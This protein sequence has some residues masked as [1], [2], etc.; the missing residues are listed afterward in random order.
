MTKLYID[1]E[2]R[3]AADIKAVG[4]HKYAADPTTEILCLGYAFDDHPVVV[5]PGGR[6]PQELA[7]HVAGGGVVVAHNIEFDALI[8]NRFF[9]LLPLKQQRCTLA[10]CRVSAIPASLDAAGKF[11]DLEHKKATTGKI[12]IGKLAKPVSTDPLVWYENA[13]ALQGLYDYCKQDVETCRALDK[14]LPDLSSAEQEVWCLDQEI[15][16]RGIKVDLELVE[17]AHAAATAAVSRL[18]DKMNE[19]T[20]GKVASHTKVKQLTEW[21]RAKGVPAESLGKADIEELLSSDLP[22][23]VRAALKIRQEAAKSSVAKYAKILSMMGE[24]NRIRGQFKYHGANTGRWAGGGVQPQNFPRLPKEKE[25]VKALVDSVLSGGV[26]TL[27]ELSSILRCTIVPRPG[28]VLMGGD[29]SAIEARVVAWLAGQ[30][31]ILEVFRSGQPVYKFAAAR[32]LEKPL[33]S[34]TEDERGLGKVVT[35]ALGYQGWIGALL[36]GAKTYKVSV[37]P[38]DA[39]EIILRWRDNNKAIVKYWA[40][41]EA[42]AASA[43]RFPGSNFPAGSAAGRVLLRCDGGTLKIKLPSSRVLYYPKAEAEH[44]WK[45]GRASVSISY[46][47]QD[48]GKSGFSRLET[49]GGSLVENITQAVAR[50]CMVH[51]MRNVS[52]RGWPIVATIHDELLT[53]VSVE[54]A[55]VSEFE[56]LMAEPPP[57][58]P[59]LPLEVEGWSD[60]RY[61]K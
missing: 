28:A 10:K 12:L 38:D 17:K 42:A 36:R 49:Y 4:A 32:L 50:D 45:Y 34:I 16:A 8:W 13:T 27:A 7:L 57:W 14:A 22:E 20:E 48:V 43:I 3:S 5:V 24:A 51:A 23:E 55:K 2:T 47:G 41:V 60:T 26:P 40:D 35:L 15:N 21:V 31:D 18:A 6:L 33:E 46:E 19:V 61:L 1:F 59:D 53:E 11:L 39:K 25:P 44:G 56:S 54:E 9:G 30:K 58:A 37:N 52:K 29:F